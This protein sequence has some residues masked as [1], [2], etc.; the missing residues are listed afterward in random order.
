MNFRNDF[1]AYFNKL[2]SRSNVI[3]DSFTFY[4]NQLSNQQSVFSPSNL[5]SGQI[6]SFFYDSM[7]RKGGFVNKRPIL[8]Y[9]NRDTRNPNAIIGLDLILMPPPYRL[10]F[11]DNLDT[12]YNKQLQEDHQI[13]INKDIL[14]T[15][16]Q[17]IPYKFSYRVYSLNKIKNIQ[18]I[19]YD[20]WVKLIYL[21]TQSVEGLSLDEIYNKYGG[22]SG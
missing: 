19:Q 16:L 11:L 9:L 10:I 1:D 6:Y 12:I 18:K 13:L 4:K 8:L 17:E 2:R 3:D 7:P 20:N 22:I 5:N 21:N 14:E 15:L